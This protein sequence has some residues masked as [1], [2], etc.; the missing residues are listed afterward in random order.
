MGFNAYMQS[1]KR[2]RMIT[3]RVKKYMTYSPPDYVKLCFDHYIDNYRYSKQ[4]ACY[5][6]VMQELGEIEPD[7]D[8]FIRSVA[9]HAINWPHLKPIVDSMQ[10]KLNC[11]PKEA[12]IYY[13][14]RQAD[15][16]QRIEFKPPRKK[17][18][19]SVGDIEEYNIV[20][21]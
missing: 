14:R 16:G 2:A 9:P 21:L 11:T 1:N 6:I 17:A 19:V 7:K 10:I 8:R 20:F 4:A 3:K 18:K 5:E 13:L 15:T 12:V